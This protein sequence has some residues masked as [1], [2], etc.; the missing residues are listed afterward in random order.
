MSRI[1]Q[2]EQRLAADPNSRM[3]VQLAEEYRKA[4]LLDDAIG[5]CEEGLKKHPD[6]LSA[7]VALGRA[8]LEAESY[9]RAGEQFE[10]VLARIPDNILANK[11][12]GETCH[13]LGRYEEAIQKYQVVQTLAPEDTELEERIQAVRDEL[14]G[15]GAA[16]AVPPAAPAPARGLASPPPVPTQPMVPSVP[17]PASHNEPTIV[18]PP[19]PA[20]L[21]EPEVLPPIPLVAVDE[22]MVLEERS[23]NVAYV[24]PIAEASDGAGLDD[25]FPVPLA[26][27]PEA[28]EVVHSGP[29]VDQAPREPE[30]VESSPPPPVAPDVYPEVPESTMVEPE[31]E[32]FVSPDEVQE[33]GPETRTM[34]EIYASQDHFEQAMTVYRKLLACNP[35]ATQ[36][37]DRIE[38]LSILAQAAADVPGASLAAAPASPRAELPAE[39]RQETIRVLEQW[40]TAIRKSRGA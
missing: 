40:L 32:M 12:L 15:A 10:A 7:Q 22:P 28:F 21:K 39:S 24:P 17:S 16:V 35:Q 4:G 25:P 3:F 36:Y 9:D 2:L 23:Y 30:L 26:A 11:F 19:V 31:L 38:E 1:E 18:E 27:E 8:L 33:A 5:V 20:A 34:A 6:Y 37:Q 14:A 13:R 29:A